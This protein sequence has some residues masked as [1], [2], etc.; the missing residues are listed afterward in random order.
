MS[1]VQANKEI[2]PTNANLDSKEIL[3]RNSIAKKFGHLARKANENDMEI[4]V[5]TYGAGAGHWSLSRIVLHNTL[6]QD[7]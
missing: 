1:T 5:F 7:P 3:R 4:G 2:I 6:F